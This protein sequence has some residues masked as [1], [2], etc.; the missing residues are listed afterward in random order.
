MHLQDPSP[1]VR[2]TAVW[3][4]AR[5]L[6]QEDFGRLKQALSPQEGDTTV[7]AEWDAISGSA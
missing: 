4:L 3:A 2:G 7:L 5:L 1:V 6:P